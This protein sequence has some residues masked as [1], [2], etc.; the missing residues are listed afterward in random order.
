M[1]TTTMAPYDLDAD[2]KWFEANLS[3]LVKRFDGKLLAVRHKEVLAAGDTVPE[4]AAKAGLP[5]GEYLI[6]RCSLEKSA[7]TVRI[8]TPGV[9][10]I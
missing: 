4:V 8:H 9:V 10:A 1:T 3:E 6:G 2:L 5:V 7:H